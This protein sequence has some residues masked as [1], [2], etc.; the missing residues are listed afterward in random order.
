M[1][2]AF[3]F[4]GMAATIDPP[5]QFWLW[6]DQDFVIDLLGAVFFYLLLIALAAFPDGIFVPRFLRW[7]IP[8]GIPLAIFVSIPDVDEDLQGIVGDRSS[9]WRSSP[10]SSSASAAS[11]PELSASRSNGRVSALPQVSC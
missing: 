2:L 7:L 9:C 4:V 3:A 1:M 6:T 5:L 11:R 8:L 10:A